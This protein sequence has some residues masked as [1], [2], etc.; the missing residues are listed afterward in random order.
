MDGPL[1]DGPLLDGLGPEGTLDGLTAVTLFSL[2]CPVEEAD[3]G[4]RCVVLETFVAGVF[5][6]DA[7]VEV[8]LLR[9]LTW[10]GPELA[11]TLSLDNG[12]PESCLLCTAE[13]VGAE[14]EGCTAVA[15]VFTSCVC[16]SLPLPVFWAVFW[17]EFW[18]AFWL[19]FCFSDCCFEL[20]RPRR[21]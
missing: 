6:V 12:V 5:S 9:V 8:S 10:V 16:E 14:F 2:S 17:P 21:L 7:L 13:T 1:L 11:R 4:S 15:G 3:F 18:L 19:A 20:R